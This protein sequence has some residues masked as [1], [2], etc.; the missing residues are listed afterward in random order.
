MIGDVYYSMKKWKEYCNS[1]KEYYKWIERANLD[2]MSEMTIISYNASGTFVDKEEF[3]DF[4]K[5]ELLID[6]I[7]TKPV[8]IY[9]VATEKV[10]SAKSKVERYKKCWKKISNLFDLSNM[11]LSNEIGYQINGMSFYLGI[12]K[13]EVSNL[14]YI[15]KIID[16]KKNYYTLIIS[17]KDYIKQIEDNEK[18]LYQFVLLNDNGE[19]DYANL[20]SLCNKNQDIACR[21]GIDSTGVELAFIVNNENIYNYFSEQILTNFMHVTI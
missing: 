16:F 14:D 18:L 11:E 17:D 9:I 20:I 1:V 19:I 6:L 2:A 5:Q 3:W 10:V 4:C 15:L 21:Y 8:Y 13:A 7:M 12:A